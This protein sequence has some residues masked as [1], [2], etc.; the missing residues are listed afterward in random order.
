MYLSPNH[1]CIVFNQLAI[2][3]ILISLFIFIMQLKERG[4]CTK[5][6]IIKGTCM[7]ACVTCMRDMHACMR[8][9]MSVTLLV[10]VFTALLFLEY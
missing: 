3:V 9:N 7:H 2:G 1:S 5:Y 6:T 10:L 4:V 8:D